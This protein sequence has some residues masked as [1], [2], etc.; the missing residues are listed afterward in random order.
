[1]TKGITL[2][3]IRSIFTNLGIN[4]VRIIPQSI[5]ATWRTGEL[6]RWEGHYRHLILCGNILKMRLFVKVT[7]FYQNVK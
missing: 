2:K 7:F 4:V 5:I 3:R 6:V 1:M